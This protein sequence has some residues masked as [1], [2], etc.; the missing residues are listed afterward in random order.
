MRLRYVAALGGVWTLS[1]CLSLD[2][3]AAPSADASIDSGWDANFPDAASGGVSATG[4]AGAAGAGAGVGAG[5]VGATAG[6]GGTTPAQWPVIASGATS[7]ETSNESTHV[8]SLPSGIQPGDLLIV[9]FGYANDDDITFPVGWT[10]PTNT[11]YSSDG[12]TAARVAYR[13]ADGTESDTISV[14]T[15]A[16]HRS[17]HQTF[18]VTNAGGGVSVD[19]TVGDSSQADPPNESPA[20]GAANTLWIAWAVTKGAA[21]AY[22]ANYSAGAEVGYGTDT[23]YVHTMTAR[24]EWNAASEDPGT[25]T[26]IADAWISGTIAVQPK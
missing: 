22:P 8:V 5:G 21:T 3:V 12:Q 23:D 19:M 4:G 13:V 7:M 1:G 26:S 16:I 25:F 24:R 20:W 2:E 10:A 18:R 11:L 9:V 15:G 17:A 14:T 6:A